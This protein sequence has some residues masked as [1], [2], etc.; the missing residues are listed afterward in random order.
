MEAI[1]EADIDMRA[2]LD[3]GSLLRRNGSARRWTE[4]AGEHIEV[5]ASES[6][7]T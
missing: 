4:S 2:K 7:N 6:S 1:E 3:N 5:V